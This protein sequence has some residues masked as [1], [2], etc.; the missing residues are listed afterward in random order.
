MHQRTLN[1]FI[2]S[3][4]VSRRVNLAKGLAVLALTLTVMGAPVRA[5]I[6]TDNIGVGGTF[7]ATLGGS[8]TATINSAS[9]TFRQWV[10]FG[11]T[12]LSVSA[13]AQTVGLTVP[14][15]NPPTM[16]ASGSIDMTY[17][18]VTPGTPS[19]INSA[20]LDLNGN[21]NINFVIN[22]QP[23]NIN[24]GSVGAQ[25][26]LTV[27]GTITNIEFQSTG[28][29]P[30]LGG[31]GGA[32]DV[33]G[34]FLITMQAS[35][36][37]ALVNVPLIN[38]VNL[39]TIF[40]IPS[41]VLSFAASLPGVVTTSDLDG[42]LPPFPNDM[43]AVYQAALSQGI[44]VPL[45]V[46]IAVS[47]TATIPNGQSGFSVLNINGSLNAVLDLSNIAY[48]LNGTVLQT[49]QPV[50]EPSSSF[51]VFAG[52]FGMGLARRRTSR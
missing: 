45:D 21:Q 19:S 52:L 25:L 20:S 31:N 36:T 44:Q 47:Q 9:G 16:A 46:P 32:Y 38:T 24:I 5:A 10:L 43:L 12:N 3:E 4:F 30:V 18:N 11:H 6:V 33:P 50:P 27:N 15:V 1:R 48:N 49:L 26:Q 17:D 41:S 8:G 37:G 42:G 22:A 51:L 2:G 34:D 7:N 23:L 40:N 39:G 14:T 35:V 28:G 13:S 29:S